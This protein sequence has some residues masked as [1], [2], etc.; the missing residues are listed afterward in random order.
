MTLK[1]CKA[2]NNYQ[3]GETRTIGNVEICNYCKNPIKK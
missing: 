2:C 3:I 1:Y